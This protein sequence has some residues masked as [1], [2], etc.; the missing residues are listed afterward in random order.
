MIALD[1][2]ILVRFLVKDDAVQTLKATNF[3]NSLTQVYP[4]FVSREVILEFFWILNGTYNYSRLKIANALDGL[5]NSQEIMVESSNN[6]RA[7]V[8]QYRNSNYDFPDLMIST[9]SK[10]AGAQELVTYD[11]K[12]SRLVGVRL[13]A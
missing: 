4:G 7:V 2:N 1:T 8:K 13:L 10:R 3:I 12:A 11:R 6:V 9:A 5:L